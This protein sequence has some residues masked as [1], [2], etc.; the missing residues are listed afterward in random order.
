M[1]IAYVRVSTEGQHLDR[2]IAKM[3]E[4]GIDERFIFSDKS[5]G[6]NFDRDGYKSMKLVLREGDVLYLDSL[7]RLGR[8]Y[9]R[10][11]TEWK[12]ITRN[13]GADIVVLDN[14][15]F[16]NSQRFREMGD[17]GKLMED[18]FLSMLSYVAEQEVKKNRT[19]AKEGIAK[20]KER[21]VHFGR[22]PVPVPDNFPKVMEMWEKQEIS[23]TDAQR[24][25]NMKPATFFRRAK[26]YR[27]RQAIS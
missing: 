17:M 18:M 13:I 19:R 2:Q 22:R 10:I 14:K 26:E 3:K 12:D 11:I 25:V 27:A 7:D 6:R 24:L 1:N 15:E 4:L 20:A 9:D 16:F 23:C 8:D 21:G 5:T